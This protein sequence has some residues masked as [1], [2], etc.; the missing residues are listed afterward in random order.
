MFAV[1]AAAGYLTID[2]FPDSNTAV[3]TLTGYYA[4]HHA[5][6]GRGGLLIGYSVIF[7]AVF[8]AAVWVRIR[9]SGAPQVLAAAALVGAALTAEDLLSSSSTYVTLG[10]VATLPT[11]TQ[12]ALQAWHIA[13]AT[14]TVSA[15]DIV[16]LVAVAAAALLARAFPRWLAWSGLVLVALQFTPFGFVSWLL[17]HLWVLAAGI[18]M[19]WRPLDSSTIAADG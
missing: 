16:L 6:V 3:S 5:Q 19:A 13:G 7:F 15:G 12:A 18:T 9:R 1:L 17:F 4:A 8:G 10:D 14:G 2:V 11:T